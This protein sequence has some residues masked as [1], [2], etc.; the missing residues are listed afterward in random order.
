MSGGLRAQ[1]HSCPG[2]PVPPTDEA[3]PGPST[4]YD[5]RPREVRDPLPLHPLLQSMRSTQSR[6]R[7]LPG[8]PGRLCAAQPPPHVPPTSLCST[9]TQRAPRQGLHQR[10]GLRPSGLPAPEDPPADPTQGA[11]ERRWASLLSQGARARGSDAPV[12]GLACFPAVS[13]LGWKPPKGQ[14]KCGAPVTPP[15]Q[16]GGRGSLCGHHWTTGTMKEQLLGEGSRLQLSPCLGQTC[17]LRLGS[18]GAWG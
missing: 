12:T 6:S 4:G 16:G 11:S 14:A 8:A 13:P 1:L 9:A 5:H 7:H 15:V 18:P 3:R 2:P 10:P 17:S